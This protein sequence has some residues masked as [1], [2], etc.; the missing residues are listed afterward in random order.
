MDETQIE[1]LPPVEENT[2]FTIFSS[3]KYDKAEQ[4][5]L[6]KAWI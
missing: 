1:K 6:L 3:S 2:P 4:L 5:F